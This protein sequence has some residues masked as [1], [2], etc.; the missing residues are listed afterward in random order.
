MAIRVPID[1]MQR[2]DSH[3]ARDRHR[4]GLHEHWF[5]LSRPGTSPDDASRNLMDTPAIR[6]V[7]IQASGEPAERVELP[8][9]VAGVLPATAD[10]YRATGFEPPWIGYVATSAGQAVGT[11][12][13]KT[14]PVAGRVEI[15]YFTFPPCEGRGFATAMARQLVGLARARYP[16]IVVTAQTLPE[17]NASNAILE[18]L[19]FRLAGVATDAEVGE[20]WEW[21]LAPGA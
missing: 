19:A 17:R 7:A 16:D 21:H 5:A 11:C 8:P 10:L 18:K 9:G 13:F 1:G 15:A 20:V 6:L 3:A 2:T 12:A 4:D 14:A